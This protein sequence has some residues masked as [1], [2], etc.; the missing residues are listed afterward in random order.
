LITGSETSDYKLNLYIYN[1]FSD[2]KGNNFC[3]SMTAAKTVQKNKDQ[4]AKSNTWFGKWIPDNFTKKA[5]EAFKLLER[6]I[7]SEEY[8]DEKEQGKI[9]KLENQLKSLQDKV[10]QLVNV[11]P[12]KPASTPSTQSVVTKTSSK[13]KTKVSSHKKETSTHARIQIRAPDSPKQSNKKVTPP[14][15]PPV[16]V[17]SV[18]SSSIVTATSGH[19]APPRPPP[20]T[21]PAAAMKALPF[22]ASDLQ[23]V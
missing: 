7:F 2:R 10:D 22:S 21:Q 9:K 18:T 14:P 4:A 1:T 12:T 20:P 8:V 19:T 13:D 23:V 11:K 3:T 5:Q 16:K 15:P 17:A 6:A